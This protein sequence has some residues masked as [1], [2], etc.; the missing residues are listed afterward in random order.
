[1]ISSTLTVGRLA[2]SRRQLRPTAAQ[3]FGEI[4]FELSASPG[5]LREV[6]R[7]PEGDYGADRHVPG[8]RL[9]D[10]G[11]DTVGDQVEQKLLFPGGR[12]LEQFY[13]TG[14]LLRAQGLGRDVECGSFGHVF[15]ICFKH[16]RAPL[17]WLGR[18][19]ASAGGR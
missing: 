8:R 15:A 14:N 9:V 1:M 13:Q 10:A 18:P 4:Q 5:E 3:A 16:G 2:L 17:R 7:L 19:S 12:I 11:R 6:D